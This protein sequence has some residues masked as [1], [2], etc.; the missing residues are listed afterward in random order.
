M[1]G[2]SEHSILKRQYKKLLDAN[3]DLQNEN[4]QLRSA[5]KERL[6]TDPT[7]LNKLL[8]IRG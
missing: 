6:Q 5:L 4:E 8:E 1:R 2:A 7:Y 3:R